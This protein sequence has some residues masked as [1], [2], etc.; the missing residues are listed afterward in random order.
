MKEYRTILP[1][2]K[3][4]IWHY[5]FGIIALIAVDVANLLI[6]QVL[7]VFGDKAQFGELTVEIVGWIALTVIGL[8]LI[9][10]IGR[11]IW[12]INI[13]GTARK[14]EYW[15]RRKLFHKYL[16]LDDTFYNHHRIGDLMAHVT[17]DVLMVRNSMGGGIVMIFDAVF[18]TVFTVI[19]MIF[20]VGLKISLIAILALPF[21]AITVSFMAKPMRQRSR[22]V[23]DT[24]SELTNEVQE[25]ISGIHNIKAFNIE[26][27]CTDAFLGVNEKYKKKNINL[28]KISALFDPLITFIAG[29]ALIVFIMYGVRGIRQNTLTLGDF[30]AVIQYVRLMVWPMVALGMVVN[31]FQRGIAAITRINEILKQEPTIKEPENPIP[32]PLDQVKLEFRNVSFRYHEDEPYILKNISFTVENQKS[33]AILGRTGSGKSTILS[34]IMRRYDVSS[35]S[36]LINDVDIRDI[37]FADLYAAIALVEQESFLFSRSIARNIAFSSDDSFLEDDIKA[38]AI[39][40]QIDQDIMQMPEQYETWVG[41][42]GVTLSGGQKQRI[43]IARAHYQDTK[44][45]I[46]DDALSAVDTNT[47]HYIL[48]HLKEYRQSLI[49]VSQ[50]VSTVKNADQIIVIENGEVVQRGNHELLLKQTGGFYEQLYHRQ[51]LEAELKNADEGS[52]E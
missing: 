19:M 4:N 41:E 27:N 50:R 12:R 23:Q 35:G 20:T 1:F 38:S 46:L 45:L 52:V 3:E 22:Q 5:I 33:L 30:I 11:F 51:L 21:L 8:G 25:N 49:L 36:I 16:Q 32:I 17:N 18:I 6:P 40:S 47:E 37:S 43:S 7:K 29:V 2:L 13:F 10:A 26:K 48:N 39:F 44:M 9:V 42:R 24:F 34:L 15:L 31:T 14:L 28:L